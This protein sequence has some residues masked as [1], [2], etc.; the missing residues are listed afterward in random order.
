MTEVDK[1]YRQWVHERGKIGNYRNLSFSTTIREAF[2]AGYAVNTARIA[3]LEAKL[4]KQSQNIDITV[5][6]C[7]TYYCDNPPCIKQQRD[8]MR[9]EMEAMQE[10]LARVRDIAEAERDYGDE[11]RYVG[12]AILEALEDE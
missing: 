10:K 8:E 1:H 6:S 11:T 3:E 12:I 4:L 5:H 9:A 2:R 7:C